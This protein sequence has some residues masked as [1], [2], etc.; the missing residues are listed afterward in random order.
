MNGTEVAYSFDTVA[1]S[2]LE[3]FQLAH[4]AMVHVAEYGTSPELAARMVNILIPDLLER[5][6]KYSIWLDQVVEWIPVL[7]ERKDPHWN[8][9]VEK[10]REQRRLKDTFQE[11]FPQLIEQVKQLHWEYSRSC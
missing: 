5:L 2:A 8:E 6:E 11:A 4:D 7:P 3:N 10:L 9:R 1:V